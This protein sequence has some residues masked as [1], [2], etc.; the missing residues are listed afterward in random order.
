MSLLNKDQSLFLPPGSIRAVLAITTVASATYLLA[1]GKLSIDE[2][3]IMVAIVVA[4]YFVSKTR[5]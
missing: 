4:F 1:S 5:W 2:Y 3:Q